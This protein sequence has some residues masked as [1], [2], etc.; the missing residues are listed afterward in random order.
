[1]D[2]L[3]DALT[4]TMEEELELEIIK[5]AIDDFNRDELVWKLKNLTELAFRQNKL[6]VAL[7]TK[8]ARYTF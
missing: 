8:L 1:M 2:D 7:I 6:I 4:L 5:R 3:K